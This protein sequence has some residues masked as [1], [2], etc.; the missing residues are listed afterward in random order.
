MRRFFAYHRAI[1]HALPRAAF[2][3]LLDALH[4]H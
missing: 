1:G 3:A 2:Y 4:L